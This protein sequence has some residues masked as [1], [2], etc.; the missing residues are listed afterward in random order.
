MQ[1]YCIFIDK[2]QVTVTW[3][4]TVTSFLL[5]ILLLFLLSGCQQTNPTPVPQVTAS[6]TASFTATILPQLTSTATLA[7]KA[8]LS[9]TLSP[10]P[11]ATKKP[12]YPI[13]HLPPVSLL[14]NG[15]DPV[16][17]EESISVKEMLEMYCEW[18]V[19][20]EDADAVY[21]WALCETFGGSAVS[22]P[23]RI[24]LSD[25]G[26][27]TCV[28]MPGDGTNYGPDIE[29]LFPMDVRERIGNSEYDLQGMAARI[30]SR[31][32]DCTYIY[33]G[34]PGC[35]RETSLVSGRLAFAGHTGVP[36]AAVLDLG[37]GEAWPQLDFSP[38]RWSP[39]GENLIHGMATVRYDGEPVGF[40]GDATVFWA[41]L[42][43]LPGAA[44]WLVCQSMDGSAF[45][46]A[47]PEQGL[48]E[49]FL[50]AG[51]LGPNGLGKLL[52][53]RENW[54]A[55]MWSSDDLVEAGRWQ[56]TLWVS[57]DL[58]VTLQPQILSEDIR[59]TYYQLIDWVPGSHLILAGKGLAGNSLWVDGVP[60]VTINAE[61]GEIRDLGVAMLLTAEA[62]QWHSQQP[63]LLAL[64]VG[65]GRF[66]FENKRLAL[67]D[68]I[69]GDLRY[70]TAENMTAFEPQWS[71]D[72][73]QLAYA[74][75][76]A[77]PGIG[78]SGQELE[79]ALQGRTIYFYDLA[80]GQTH[81]ITSPSDD[82]VDGWPRWSR[83]GARLLYT[84]QLSGSTSVRVITLDGSVDEDLLLGLVD[85]TCYDGGCGWDRYLA[86]A[87]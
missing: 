82:A 40:H 83:D 49:V 22:L 69:S 55:W 76:T 26:H 32:I 66:I 80:S 21:I 5:L 34:L 87:P 79:L 86:Y 37:T 78:G 6:Q 23:V 73:S 74:A 11:I 75:L 33:P 35:M 4:V 68:A 12:N 77:T 38:L 65:G 44:D 8:A 58:G 25:A 3:K 57:T 50:P 13:R 36:E 18:D 16:E 71:P 29:R 51:S 53:S 85:P 46:S 17:V 56:Q 42:N 30:L 52:W 61:T 1:R 19:L 2:W 59:E 10:T 62:Y 54:L 20:G 28:E 31:K 47:V 41:P 39:S 24:N 48:Y 72:G 27:F 9:L 60:L 45:A 7:P 70:L 63:G 43:A 64:A 15:L 67:L 84:R 81:Q 14:P